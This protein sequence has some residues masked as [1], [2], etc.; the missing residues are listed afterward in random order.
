M[1]GPVVALA[2]A[3]QVVPEDGRAL[4]RQQQQQQLKELEEEEEEHV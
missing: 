2:T 1:S 3:E 4:S